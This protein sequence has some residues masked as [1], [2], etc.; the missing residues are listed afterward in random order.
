[1]KKIVLLFSAIA[2]FGVGAKAQYPLVAIDSLQYMNPQ[3]LSQVQFAVPGS[4]GTLSD[5][6]IY[7][8]PNAVTGDTVTIEGVVIFDPASYGL[9]T[10]LSRQATFIQ[11]NIGGVWKGV[12]V[13]YDSAVQPVNQSVV[14]F[15][16]NMKK[17]RV[18]RV[19]GRIRDFQGQT[20]LTVVNVPTEVVSLGPVNPDPVVLDIEDFVRLVGSTQTPQFETGEPYEGVYVE[21]RNV[22]VVRDPGSLG[23]NLPR[24]TWW[25][26]DGNG[27]RISI[28]DVSGYFRNDGYDEDPNTPVSFTP[29]PNGSIISYIRGVIV[30]SGNSSFK[31]Y[32]IAP[33]HP[34]DV[35]PPIQPP[36]IQ[37][38]RRTPTLATSSDAVTFTATITDADGV[39]GVVL[40]YAVG[41]N[42][43][44]FVQ[45]PMTTSGADIYTATVP[46]QAD[47][48]IVKYFITATDNAGYRG[49]HLDST[50]LNSAYRV[51]NNLNTVNYIQETPLPNGASL[52]AGDTLRNINLHATVISTINAYDLGIIAVQSNTNPWGTIFVR[53]ATGDG[54]IN[55][56]RGD[57]VWIKKALVTERIPNGSNPFGRVSTSGVTFLEEIGADGW[58]YVARCVPAQPAAKVP[59]DSLISLTF[60][61]EPYENMLI[62][63]N[64][65]WVV[66]KNADSITGGNF[67]EFVVNPDITKYS[68]LRADDYSNDLFTNRVSDSLNRN[69]NDFLPVFRGFLLNTYGNWKFY[70]RDRADMSKGSNGVPPYITRIG[71]DTLFVVRGTAINDPG[72]SACD[73]LQGDVSTDVVTDSSQVDINANGTYT[74]YYNVSDA[75]GNEAAEVSRVVV[76]TSGLSV[77]AETLKAA[78]YPVPAGNYLNVRLTSEN[79]KPVV[80][81]IL[82]A[83]G[84]VVLERNLAVNTDMPETISLNN[85]KSGVYFCQ[86]SSENSVITEKIT[87]IR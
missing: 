66:Q 26:Q 13:M 20:Q 45:V 22:T 52:F 16:Q 10:S 9:S 11:T 56:K 30:E 87:V 1:M 31:Q 82:D 81:R 84:T 7:T 55:W 64:D 53:F 60:N 29:P 42:N 23:N 75:E 14:L 36:A 73:D 19:T 85:L 3:R 69:G 59:F 37:N 24:Y 74:L 62:E 6:M 49:H 32:S 46:A 44:T 48:S 80:F 34:T 67:G 12:E 43:N 41:Y 25:V 27:N 33:L 78:I 63:V 2:A 18:V 72:A 68:G 58:E 21:F 40:N 70:P 86:F 4:D 61:K 54:V 5:Y 38:V 65:V 71:A 28:R 39:Q 17:G 8:A 77:G 76:V 51:I 47:G 35:A 83:R 15:K 79:D 50:G 57:S